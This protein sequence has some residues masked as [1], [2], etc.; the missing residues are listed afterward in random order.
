[1]IDAITDAVALLAIRPTEWQ[2]HEDGW[3]AREI[4]VRLLAVLELEQKRAAE[5]QS[6]A[7]SH[8]VEVAQLIEAAQDLVDQPSRPRAAQ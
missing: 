2:S 7:Q 8:V 5:W 6:L 1:M 4:V 3:R